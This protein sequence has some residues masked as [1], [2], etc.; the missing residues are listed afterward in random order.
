MY[1]CPECKHTSKDKGGFVRHYGLVHKM[2]QLF[3]K[4]MGIH[5]FEELSP[6]SGKSKMT[7]QS[8]NVS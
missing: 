8:N 5:Q 4:E 7:K 6:K 3:L 1:K 2:V